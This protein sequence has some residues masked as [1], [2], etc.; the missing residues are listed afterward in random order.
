MVIDTFKIQII[1]WAAKFCNCFFG[2]IRINRIDLPDTMTIEFLEVVKIQF[3]LPGQIY[4][5][6][7]NNSCSLGFPNLD[8]LS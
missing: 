8:N 6:L 2:D 4:L 1:H 3:P 7:A 5:A